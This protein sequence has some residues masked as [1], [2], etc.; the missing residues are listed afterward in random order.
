MS[1]TPASG[2]ITPMAAANTQANKIFGYAKVAAVEF[3]GEHA[4]IKLRTTDD[5]IPRVYSATTGTSQVLMEAQIAYAAG[6]DVVFSAYP[7][8]PMS[9]PAAPIDVALV[10]VEMEQAVP[11]L[12]THTAQNVDRS[13]DPSRPST[14]RP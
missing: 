13:G 10:I 9:P 6:S 12:A 1:Q 5:D 4:W 11:E 14:T 3:D 2:M 8:D 7:A